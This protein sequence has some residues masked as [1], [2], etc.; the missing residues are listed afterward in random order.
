MPTRMTAAAAAEAITE[1]NSLIN[2]IGLCILPLFAC[3]PPFLPSF[4][5][6]S[7]HSS[8]PP[9]VKRLMAAHNASDT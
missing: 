5:P 4:L 2:V 1:S 8:I 7:F 6:F 3:L 9:F